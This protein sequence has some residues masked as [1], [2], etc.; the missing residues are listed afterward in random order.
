MFGRVAA[1]LLNKKNK[2]FFFFGDFEN[3]MGKFMCAFQ[4]EFN[5][6]SIH[7]SP[8]LVFDPAY[9]TKMICVV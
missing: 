8:G 2:N 6:K 9:V 4:F 5:L 3:V 1:A 7:F